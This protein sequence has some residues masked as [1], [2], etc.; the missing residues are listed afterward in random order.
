M[1]LPLYQVD[2]FA[3]EVFKGNPAAVIPLDAWLEEE[4]E[5]AAE[6]IAKLKAEG[7]DSLMMLCDSDEADIHELASSVGMAKLKAKSFNKR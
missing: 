4:C 6:V 3:N 2:A 5:L 7:V 1:M